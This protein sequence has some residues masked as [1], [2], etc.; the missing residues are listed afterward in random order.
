MNLNKLLIYFKNCKLPSQMSKM[1]WEDS[2]IQ[3][4]FASLKRSNVSTVC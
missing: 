2:S 1:L 3:F 4:Y